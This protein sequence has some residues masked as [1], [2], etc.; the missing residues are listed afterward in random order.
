MD[1]PWKIFITIKDFKNGRSNI[2]SLSS[3]II[4]EKSEN[5]LIVKSQYCFCYTSE[6]F[7]TL[8]FNT[9]LIN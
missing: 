1:V 8:N 9:N 4:G 7:S 2:Y 5:K 6:S 3:L